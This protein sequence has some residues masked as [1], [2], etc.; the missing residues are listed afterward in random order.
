MVE[1][2]FA[3]L[4]DRIAYPVWLC[5]FLK[6]NRTVRKAAIWF[7]VLTFGIVHFFGSELYFGL[8]ALLL[9]FVFAFAFMIFQFVGI[10]WF[11]SRPKTITVLPGDKT[12]LTLEDYWGQPALVELVNQWVTILQGDQAFQEM[13]GEPIRGL[14]L[15]GAPGTGKTYL[16]KCLAGS[17]GISLHGIEGC[18]EVGTPVLTD[19]GMIPI[20]RVAIGDRVL[21]LP[22]KW[23]TVT[24]VA[25]RASHDALRL[26]TRA[27][28][29]IICSPDHPLWVKKPS[30]SGPRYP[31][32]SSRPPSRYGK[33]C[34][35]KADCIALS[36]AVGLLIEPA[37]HGHT[38]L[39]RLDAWLLGMYIAEGSST[40]EYKGHRYRI[41]ISSQD[42]NLRR[43][44][45]LWAKG[46]GFH[47]WED[48]TR[49]Q[50]SCGV[51]QW[52]EKA[53]INLSEKAYEKRMP[54]SIMCAPIAIRAA[55]VAGLFDGDG[56]ARRHNQSSEILYHTTSAKL[57]KDIQILLASM[58]IASTRRSYLPRTTTAFSERRVF[59]LS[60]RGSWAQALMK[61]APFLRLR[62]ELPKT[63]TTRWARLKV[64][65][66]G[67][68]WD[69]VA[70]IEPTSAKMYDL[71]VQPEHGA[72]P[73]YC[74]GA[75]PSHNS[76]F[77][78][79]F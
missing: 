75:F 21:G 45:R 20:E 41:S 35:L 24:H 59:E 32:G 73:S 34:W 56:C 70:S 29:E 25:Q 40:A 77:R 43:A 12:E 31:N 14:L 68:V 39:N 33:P 66:D 22:S 54:L 63:Q 6:R 17:A 64:G 2:I 65:K 78:A 79:M 55:F 3:W 26:R 27:G 4:A 44:T 42:Y 1:G 28:Y 10:F 36:D 61:D 67:L 19:N 71:E 8:L 48:A 72:D 60:I 13:G 30:G 46:H 51:I 16:M 9:Q 38:D 57:S 47:V 76:S 49:V 7:A 52:M 18:V 58:G 69:I 23:G 62:L 37:E 50:I 5:R 15:Q 11:L 53:G 74:A